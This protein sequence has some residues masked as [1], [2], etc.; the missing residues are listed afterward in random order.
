MP[1]LADFFKRVGMIFRYFWL[2]WVGLRPL[3]TLVT[4]EGDPIIFA[5]AYDL[6]WMRWVP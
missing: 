2:E 5:K 6:G 4:A 3:P 1:Q